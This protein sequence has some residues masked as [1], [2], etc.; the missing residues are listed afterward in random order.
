MI[1]YDI[2]LA[3]DRL[4]LPT[5]LLACFDIVKIENGSETMTIYLDE[6]NLPPLSSSTLAHSLESKGFLPAIEIRDFP[7]RDN[8][9]TLYV[10][11]RKWID[12]TTHQIICNTLELTANGT[13]HSKEF[14]SFLK[15]LLWRNARLRLALLNAIITLT[16]I[17]LNGSTKNI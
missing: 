9:V 8:K 14:A 2:L 5:D 3:L 10:R 16:A 7:I 11:R 17:C 1:A 15:G 6:Q 12:R 4:I 13:R